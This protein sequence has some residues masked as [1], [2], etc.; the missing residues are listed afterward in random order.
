MNRFVIGPASLALGDG[1]SVEGRIAIEQ[2][3]AGAIG[4]YVD[5][6]RRDMRAGWKAVIARAVCR[7]NFAN[8][9]MLYGY[10]AVSRR[11]I[12]ERKRRRAEGKTVSCQTRFHVTGP[13]VSPS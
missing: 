5:E 1:S 4:V 3:F 6:P 9:A 8:A 11:T 7:E 2:E 12:A 10:A 13:L